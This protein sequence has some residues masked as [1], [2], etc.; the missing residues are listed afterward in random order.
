MRGHTAAWRFKNENAN[1]FSITCIR[2][3]IFLVCKD[4][5]LIAGTELRYP[6]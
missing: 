4:Y 6:M 1:S 2:Q 3:E 5:R